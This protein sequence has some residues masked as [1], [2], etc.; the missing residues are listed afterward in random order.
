MTYLTPHPRVTE[1]RCLTCLSMRC[2]QN[3]EEV[4]SPNIEPV[5]FAG[6]WAS[7]WQCPACGGWHV[8][9]REDWNLGPEL[10]HSRER[11]A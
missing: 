5:E 9:L 2:P 7:W 3:D 10:K 11:T 1:A 8:T 6:G 4:V